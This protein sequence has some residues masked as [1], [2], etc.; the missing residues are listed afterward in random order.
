MA[1]A[2]HVVILR[3]IPTRQ[4]IVMKERI[5]RV[6]LEVNQLLSTDGITAIHT[7]AFKAKGQISY[8]AV[9]RSKSAEL[10]YIMELM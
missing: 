6:R 3:A 7:L 10:S 4:D 2:R 5:Q 8:G 9:D 1:L